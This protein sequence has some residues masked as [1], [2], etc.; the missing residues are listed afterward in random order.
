M[1]HDP[2]LVRGGETE[3]VGRGGGHLVAGMVRVGSLDGLEADL[4]L[5]RGHGGGGFRCVL[6]SLQS[7]EA[8]EDENGREQVVWLVL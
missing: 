7:V 3:V 8:R 5:G 1:A 2:L 6:G 4:F